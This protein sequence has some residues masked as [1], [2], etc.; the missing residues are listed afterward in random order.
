MNL[1]I[2]FLVSTGPAWFPDGRSVMVHG[3]APQRGGNRQYRVDLTTGRAELMSTKGVTIHSRLSPDGRAI[4]HGP[5]PLR[6][7]DVTSQQVVT[8][9]EEPGVGYLSPTVSPDGNQIAYWQRSQAA[10]ISNIVVAKRDGTDARAV[11]ACDSGTSAPYN[12]LTWMP[13]QRHLVF[14]DGGGVLWRVAVNGG[15][16]EELG[17]S[18][19]AGI[20][21]PH[22]QPDGRGIYF[23]S[24]DESAPAELWALEDFLRPS[25]R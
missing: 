8:L 7:Q 1:E 5:N 21:G 22:I 14:A 19:P 17:V 4:L 23:T 10:G 24:R 6:W 25:A 16:P 2:N 13:D 3:S 20:K 15:K 9:K 11:C 18:M 12:V